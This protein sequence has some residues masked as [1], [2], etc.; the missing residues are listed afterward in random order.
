MI[1]I[2]EVSSRVFLMLEA[3]E[4]IRLIKQPISMNPKSKQQESPW[5]GTGRSHVLFVT[6]VLSHGQDRTCSLAVNDKSF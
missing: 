3:G 4:S 5:S 6:A 2:C 1:N